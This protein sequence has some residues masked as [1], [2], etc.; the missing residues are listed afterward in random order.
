LLTI[1]KAKGLEFP[2]VVLV[3]GALRS[4]GGREAVRPL[5]DRGA[6]RLAV[7]LK[8]ELPGAAARDLEPALYKELKEREDAME[9]SELRRLL[10]VAATRARDHLVVSCFGRLTTQMGDA[11][12]GVMLAPIR[13][14]LPAPGAEPP[15]ADY[16]LGDLLDRGGQREHG[17]GPESGALP[18][19]GAL[20]VLAP[21]R[22]PMAAERCAAPDID[23]LLA[24]RSRW[25]AG[26]AA[27]LA[28]GIRPA[29]ATSPS[30][31]EHVDEEV[32]GGGPGAPPGRA[33]ALAL[34]S[35]V[36]RIMEL[37]DLSDEASIERLATAVTAEA[38]RP[39]LAKQAAAL[40]GAC[41][42][43]SPVRAAA[44][45]SA[46]YRELP[47]GVL[48]DDIVVTGAVDLLYR[49]G[50]EWVIVDY[51]TDRGSDGRAVD[52]Q[53]LRERYTPQGAAYAVAVERATGRPVREVVLV[54]AAADGRA[55]HIAVDGGLRAAAVREIG[56]A[57]DEDR[58]VRPDGL[59]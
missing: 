40:A 53:L 16:E 22:P 46:L 33:T 47:V 7:K 50:D 9:A 4:G 58:A 11:A 20:L 32:R 19:H 54:A 13:A 37:C 39:D 23:A 43:S 28:E 26:R 27:L 21:Q 3:G 34:G 10:Y 31:L 29:R 15:T 30:G 5:V 35:A 41:W 56:V 49:D 44:C 14:N 8:A 55:V 52:P 51:K 24:E 42:R 48:V 6:R 45:A 59:A 12:A 2:I 17:G 18:E 1:H 38:G 25:M 57:V 36:H